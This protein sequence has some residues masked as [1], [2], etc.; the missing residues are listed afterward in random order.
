MEI[1]ISFLY[2]YTIIRNINMTCNHEAIA[3]L[4]KRSI[5]WE[6]YGGNRY[7]TVKH[8][9]EPTWRNLPFMVIVCP[10]EGVYH[11]RIDG[12][13]MVEIYPG[14]VLIAPKNLKYTVA[15]PEGGILHFAHIQYNLFGSTDFMSFFKVPFLL[16]GENAVLIAETVK[17]LHIAM[18]NIPSEGTLFQQTARRMSLALRLLDLV[19]A[20]SENNKDGLNCFNNILRIEPALRYMEKHLSENICRRHLAKLSSLSE[21]RFH[22]VFSQATGV[23]PMTYLKNLRMARAQIL[24]FQSDHSINAIGEMVGYPDVYHFS[25]KFKSTFAITPSAYRRDSRQQAAVMTV[26]KHD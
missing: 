2:I 7:L 21:T 4:L 14:E 22:F 26:T 15:M 17:E 24:L 19:T 12:I 13:G 25:K 9:E 10:L 23:A 5:S 3:A 18:T 11:S 8:P 6:Y 1:H 16:R 20:S